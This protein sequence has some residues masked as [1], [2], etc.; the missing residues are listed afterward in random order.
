MTSLTKKKRRAKDAATTA[1][2]TQDRVETESGIGDEIGDEGPS[3][4]GEKRKKKK[5]KFAIEKL[6]GGVA[7][8]A[9]I[10]S[11]SKF[12][13][14]NLSAPTFQAIQEDMKFEYMTEVWC[15]L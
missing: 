11:E 14:L 2:I 15:G 13:S 4:E 3:E 7:R 6:E 1:K 8:V 12:S 5:A 10:I 9:G